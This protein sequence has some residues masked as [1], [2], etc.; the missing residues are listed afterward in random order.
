MITLSLTTTYD[1]PSTV[2][3]SSVSIIRD[4]GDSNK[5]L[6]TIQDRKHC[7][8]KKNR[9]TSLKWSISANKISYKTADMFNRVPSDLCRDPNKFY[10]QIYS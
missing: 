4:V 2:Q 1:G 6:Y 9:S 7:L 8:V 3:M 10:I 5:L